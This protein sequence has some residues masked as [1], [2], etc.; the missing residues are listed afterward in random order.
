MSLICIHMNDI[1]I[2][3]HC[4]KEI[5]IKQFSRHLWKIHNQKYE[6][7]VK[8]NLSEFLHLNWKLCSECHV[9]FHGTSLKCGKCYTKNHNIKRDQYIQ[10]RYCQT[11]IHSK[12]MPVHLNAHHGVLFM[13]YV[14]EHLADFEKMGW[15]KCFVC[16]NVT[17]KRGNKHETTCSE[18][19]LSDYR[20]TLTGE[21]SIR[22]GAILSDETKEK[23]S[24][25]NTGIKKPTI[26]GSLN[27]ACRSEVREQISKTRIELGLSKG[28]NNPMFGKTH[29]PE[30]VAKIFS[31]RKMNKLEK[32]VADELDKAGVSYSFQFFIVKDKT[33][34][35]YDFKIK[36]KPIII[37]VDGDF[38]HGNPNTKNH[39]IGVEKTRKNDK[40]KDELAASR[41]YKVVR[42]W[43]RDIKKDPSI[44]PKYVL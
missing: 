44:V 7:Y 41:E 29:T 8:D 36:G 38:W 26:Q 28:S 42:L 30:A 18:N 4:G 14:K 39:Y 5:G 21:K 6:D 9:L 15:C 33:C 27:P 23:I 16:G 11:P 3:K 22:F 1:F 40:R 24:V 17:K 12:V 19:C 31:H 37:E 35:S 10:C 34:K 43:E 32:I 2:C 20:K 13:D 25:S